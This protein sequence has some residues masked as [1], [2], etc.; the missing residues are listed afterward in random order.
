MAPVDPAV[1]EELARLAELAALRALDPDE[2][3]RLSEH[4]RD[5]CEDCLAR[6]EQGLRAL[7]ILTLAGPVAAPSAGARAALLD[8]IDAPG[9][10]PERRRTPVRRARWRAAL[11]AMAAGLALV[12]AAG[13]LF[14][15][16]RVERDAAAALGEARAQLEARLAERDGS[17]E[18]LAA[19]LAHSEEVLR[20]KAAGVR[21][22]TLAGEADFGAASARVVVDR[23]GNQVLLLASRLPPAPRGH[24]YQLWVI[25]SGT[26]RS[27]GVFDADTEGRALHVESEPL[28]LDDDDFRIAIS[29]EP[30][31]G[32]PQPTGPIVLASH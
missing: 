23:A 8:A 14:T 30:S 4:L 5:G 17:V 24:T 26:P 20:A 13:A 29:V 11:P 21:E 2:H 6:S 10:R 15:A 16:R 7:D 1:H 28:H 25:V 3:R 18:A 31:G 22:V 27:L 12:L 9:A 19:R 32:V